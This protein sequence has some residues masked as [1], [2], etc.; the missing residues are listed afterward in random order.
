MKAGEEFIFRSQQQNILSLF[1]STL[2]R[3]KLIDRANKPIELLSLSFLQIFMSEK[4][5]KFL[6]GYEWMEN[7]Q[8]WIFRNSSLRYYAVFFQYFFYSSKVTYSST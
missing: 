8:T 6:P 5:I 2:R 4:E 7:S 1:P 3:D